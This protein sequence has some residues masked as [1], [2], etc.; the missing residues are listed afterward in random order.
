MHSVTISPTAEEFAKDSL[1]N[2]VRQHCP[3]I[4][5]YELFEAFKVLVTTEEI[6]NWFHTLN[7]TDELF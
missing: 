7:G 6:G 5:H 4:K 3:I 1:V 2:Y